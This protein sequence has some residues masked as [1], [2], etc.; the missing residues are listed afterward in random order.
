M[1][2]A[3]DLGD[4]FATKRAKVMAASGGIS[5]HRIPEHFVRRWARVLLTLWKPVK[6]PVFRPEVPVT[7][8][9]RGESSN[10]FSF[11]QMSQWSQ[12]STEAEKAWRKITGAQMLDYLKTLCLRAGPWTARATGTRKRQVAAFQRIRRI[13]RV[14][15]NWD[16]LGP[17]RDRPL[18]GVGSFPAEVGLQTAA[19]RPD[20]PAGRSGRSLAN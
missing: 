12:W 14:Q 8:P 9:V 17:D 19:A 13:R 11:K 15:T 3:C 2:G 10:S 1:R 20:S 18:T 4:G 7:V 5:G 6:V 16:L